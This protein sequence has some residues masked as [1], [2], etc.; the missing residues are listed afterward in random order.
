M[1]PTPALDLVHD[2]EGRA[3]RA[4]PALETR[5]VG[6]WIQRLSGGYTKRAN[7]INALDI[8]PAF[9]VDLIPTLEAP[10]HERGLPPVWRLSPLA[11]AAADAALAA[12]GYRRIDETF[13]QRVPLAGRG[14]ALDPE[15]TIAAAPSTAWLDGFASLSPVAPQHR[16]AMTKMLAMIAAPVG[17]LSV[18][19]K[20]ALVAFALGVVDGDHV[21][22]FDVLVAPSA[23][24]RGLARRLTESLCAWGTQHGAR[25][26]YLQVV[27]TNAAALPLYARL[28]FETVYSYAYR[29][30]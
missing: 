9:A 13:V 15:V 7:S 21:G 3:F 27:A 18:A 6:G 25:F 11:P 17:F 4:W 2:V 1:S 14:F 5:P 26:A 30:P 23:R 8:E 24:R 29:V 19:D 12:K 10:Y 16:D 22:I 20:G 28:G